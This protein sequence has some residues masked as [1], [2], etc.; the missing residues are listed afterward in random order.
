MAKDTYDKIVDYIV[1]NQQKFYR[2]AYCYVYNK[3]S[4]LDIVQN[5]ICKAL[6]HYHGLRNP[7]AVKTWFYRILVNES[8]TYIKK[9]GR[10]IACEPTELKEEVYYE[11][12]FEPGLAVYEEINK[13]SEE[14]Q[15][16]VVL[17]FFEQ[18]TLKEVSQVT[19]VNLNTVKSRLYAALAKLK[20]GL[21]EEYFDG[22]SREEA[23]TR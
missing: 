14:M 21:K 16:V 17:H 9:N 12:K 7:D 23:V 22:R 1:E 3:D 19:G 13:L 18:L 20:E 8:L 15:T 2:I 11:P 4:A 5:A 10:E 6:E